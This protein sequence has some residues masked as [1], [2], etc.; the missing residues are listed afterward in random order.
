MKKTATIL[1]TTFLALIVSVISCNNSKDC[2]P[3]E[4]KI[5]Y[6]HDTITIIP[7]PEEVCEACL[8]GFEAYTIFYWDSIQDDRQSELEIYAQE[9]QRKTDSAKN[10]WNDIFNQRA[11]SLRLYALKLD[12]LKNTRI[13]DNLIIHSDSITGR[14]RAEFD[15]ETGKPVLIFE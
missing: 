5:V 13:Y 12:S 1:L 8:S 2:P 6:I 3:E 4:T 9:Q 15:S 7:S 14:A 11:D 10:H